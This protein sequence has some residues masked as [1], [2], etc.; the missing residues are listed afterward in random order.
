MWI[1]VETDTIVNRK[2]L[3]T[4]NLSRQLEKKVRLSVAKTVQRVRAF[5]SQYH[6]LSGHFSKC[7]LFCA[8]SVKVSVGGRAFQ[9]FCQLASVLCQY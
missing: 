1:V 7:A 2:P 9:C 8:C 3:G 4:S 6:R 5:L